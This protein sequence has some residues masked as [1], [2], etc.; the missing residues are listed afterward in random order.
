MVKKLSFR[1]PCA[2]VQTS[3]IAHLSDVGSYAIT[4]TVSIQEQSRY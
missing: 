3:S 1:D 4:C 2:G